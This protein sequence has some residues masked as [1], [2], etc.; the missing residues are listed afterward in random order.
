MAEGIVQIIK[1]YA[2]FKL[3]N[4]QKKS[5]RSWF[6]TLDKIDKRRILILGAAKIHT[7]PS[8]WI[9]ENYNNYVNLSS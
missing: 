1:K 5:N 3:G 9:F 2:Y 4:K 8:R 6:E 7:R